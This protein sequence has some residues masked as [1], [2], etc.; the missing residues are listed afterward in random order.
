MKG[1]LQ[2]VEVLHNCGWAH[3]HIKMDNVQA[4]ISAHRRRV[5]CQV[6]DLGCA[7]KAS[8]RKPHPHAIPTNLPAMVTNFDAKLIL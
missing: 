3:M 1:C 7:I 4:D 6:I 2:G 5:Q 8:A